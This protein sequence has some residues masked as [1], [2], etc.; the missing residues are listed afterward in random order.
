MHRTRSV[1]RYVVWASFLSGLGCPQLLA[2]DF[3]TDDTCTPYEVCDKACVD[4]QSDPLHCGS[5]GQ[6][7]D[8]SQICSLGAAIAAS[9]GCGA[10]TLCN[11]GCV[12]LQSHPF[13]C[14]SC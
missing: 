5:C 6:S 10:Q 9:D 1:A 7:V 8:G 11:G 3:W 4:L 2:D 14:G 13:F 12:D